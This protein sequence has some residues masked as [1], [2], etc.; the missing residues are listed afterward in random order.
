MFKSLTK[1]QNIYFALWVVYYLQG[2]V[3]PTGSIISQFVLLLALLLSF[4]HIAKV[5]AASRI[6]SFLKVLNIFLLLLTLYGII[7][8]L[9]GE[10]YM[11]GNRVRSKFEPLKNVYIS[12]LPIYSFY[13][14]TITRKITS[15]WIRTTVLF[16]LVLVIYD[17]FDYK[18]HALQRAIEAGYDVEEITNNTGY[19]FCALIPLIFFLRKKPLIQYVLLFTCVAF[20]VMAMKRGAIII[21]SLLVVY[22]LY[23]TLSVSSKKQRVAVI[24]L[25]IVGIIAATYFTIDFVSNSE[26][27][28][29]RLNETV[30]GNSSSRD[31]IFSKLFNYY[32][33]ETSL[34]QFL[35]GGGTYYSI[36]IAGNL[37]HNDWLELAVCQ[38]MLGIVV[39]ICYFTCLRK[40]IS[41]LKR[42][43]CDDHYVVMNMVFVI[44]FLSTLFSMSYGS[45]NLSTVI[46][47]GFCLGQIPLATKSCC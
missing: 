38:G 26:Y 10:V 9:V 8:M 12:L 23:K 42:M 7:Y 33:N 36:K 11:A 32:F 3:Y 21:S 28:Q 18:I 31:I 20:V 19:A 29:Y 37:A 39:Y 44:M 40:D 6:P 24:I 45:L 4:Y 5:N 35:F 25:S 15:Q 17:F 2:L 22:F 34:T 27:F 47:L 14:F 43:R 13:Y 16:L 46:A 30:E 41:I 1:Q